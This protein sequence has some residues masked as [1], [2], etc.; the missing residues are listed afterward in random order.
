MNLL[1]PAVALGNVVLVPDV[2]R[3]TVSGMTIDIVSNSTKANPPKNEQRQQ[4]LVGDAH[5]SFLL[6]QMIIILY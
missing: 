6:L 1:V 5:A 2:K 3:V 4:H